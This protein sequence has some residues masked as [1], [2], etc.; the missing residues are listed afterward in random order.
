[1]ER[2]K[3]YP[4][5]TGDDNPFFSLTLR[6]LPKGMG[7]DGLIFSVDA[8]L[9]FALKDKLV[10]FATRYYR[11]HEIVGTTISDFTDNLQVDLDMNLDTFEKMLQVYDEDIAK[12]T[13][14]REIVRTYDVTDTNEGTATNESSSTSE[15]N[16]ENTNYDIPVDNGTAQ[17]T[18]K[19]V[20]NTTG[21]STGR[22]TDTQ[23]NTAKKTGTETEYWSDV[24]VAPNYELL[25]G[26]LDN[27]RT[28]YN[29]FVSF[30][31]DDFTV[32]E[33]YHD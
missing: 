28:L 13:Q 3:N 21:S 9:T 1:M 10:D 4:S 33:V 17:G 15:G 31:K 11:N 30:F 29:V 25:N 12:P 23:S 5:I 26:F 22:S 19:N 32:M 14:S 7:F 27:N 18:D 2:L 6:D 16:N 24:G 8:P 20:G